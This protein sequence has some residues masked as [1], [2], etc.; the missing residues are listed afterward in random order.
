MKTTR[1]CAAMPLT[2]EFTVEPFLPGS[3]GPH[4]LAAVAAAR[5]A[6]AA[7]EIGPFANALSGDDEAV[8]GAIQAATRAAVEHGATHVSVQVSRS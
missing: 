2:A 1:L 3:P 4:V 7:V 6:G 8:L 5:A